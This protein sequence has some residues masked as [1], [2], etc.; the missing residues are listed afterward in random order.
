VSEKKLQWQALG[1]LGVVC[2]FALLYAWGGMEHKEIR[3]FIA[4]TLLVVAM[5]YYS[6]WDWRVFLQLPFMFASLSLGYGGDV[7]WIKIFR[8]GLFGLANGISSSGFNIVYKRWGLVI[9]TV[10][11]ITG[12]SVFLGVWNPMPS[13]RIEEL[14]IGFIIGFMAL[15]SVKKRS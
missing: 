2:L 3:R 14:C 12:T 13:A 5:F 11:L 10:L 8:R 15:M 9:F 7:F 4:P 1:R 6:G